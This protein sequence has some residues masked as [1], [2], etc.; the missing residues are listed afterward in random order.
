MIDSELGATAGPVAVRATHDV[1]LKTPPQSTI[2]PL[3]LHGP[4]PPVSAGPS[5]PTQR[6]VPPQPPY[7]QPASN[8][9][10]NARAPE[11]P[12]DFPDLKF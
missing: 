6:A 11:E 10:D 2:P 8:W 7:Q 1:S 9:Q 4:V 5:V 3:P 12:F